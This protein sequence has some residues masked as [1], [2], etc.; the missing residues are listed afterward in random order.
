MTRA[1]VTTESILLQL[2]FD[3][4]LRMRVKAESSEKGKSTSV[5]EDTTDEGSPA[6]SKTG[7][8]S[9]IG[10]LT[11][12]VTIDLD[13]ITRARD[14]VLLCELSGDAPLYQSLL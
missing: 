5:S 11:N 9:F 14:M 2:V 4:S 13:N 12:L 1:L 7:T 6:A 10:R 3:Y 8:S